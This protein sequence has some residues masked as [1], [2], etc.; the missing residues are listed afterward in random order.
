MWYLFFSTLL[1]TN[2][3]LA[4]VS[5]AMASVDFNASAVEKREHNATTLKHRSPTS[6]CL[7]CSIN[8]ETQNVS[9]R[10][11]FAVLMMFNFQTQPKS[12]I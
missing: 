1:Q 8:T 4:T 9:F 6:V 5:L 7:L 12:F 10:S 11:L 3:F 2:H